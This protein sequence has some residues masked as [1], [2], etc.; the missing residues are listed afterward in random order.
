MTKF[1][2]GSCCCGDVEFTMKDDFQHFF[3]CHCEQ[4]RKLTGC[5]H[6]AN[7]FTTPDNIHWVKGEAK[8]KRYNHPTRSFSQAFCENC[9]SGLPHIT[10]SGDAL[11]V[12]AGI[13]NEEPSKA[14]DAQIFCVEETRWYKNGLDV[15]KV[16]GFPE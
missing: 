6:A 2:T 5:A 8:I 15:V 1:L 7:L 3:F 11:L 12:P 16:S 4:C 14:L 9:G 13:L 10:Q